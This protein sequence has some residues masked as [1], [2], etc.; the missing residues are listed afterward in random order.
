MNKKRCNTLL[1]LVQLLPAV[2]AAAAVLFALPRTAPVLAAVP[3]RLTAVVE[4]PVEAAS[5]EAEEE[6]L[7]KLPYAD[8]VYVGSSRGYGGAVRV[9]VT[10]EN[11]SIAEVEI[12]DASHETKQFLRRAK[13]LLTT[14][15]DAQSWEVDAVSEATYTSRGILGAV[16]NALTGEVVNN[17]LPPQPKPSAPLVVEEFTAPSTYRDGIY[18]AEA[19]GFEGKITVQVTVA[20]DKITDITVLSAEDEEEYLSRAKRVIPAILEGQSPNVDAV[21]GATYSSTGILNAVKLALAKAA[22]A[23]A[24][25][26]TPEQTASEEVVEEAAP[27][28]AAEPEETPVTAPT[29]EVVQPKEKRTVPAWLKEVWQQLF[30]AETPDDSEPEPASSAEVLLASEAVLPPEETEPETEGAAE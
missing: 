16:Q 20:E 21:S 12:L 2:A 5:V 26:T 28:E 10:M 7:P 4:Q 18:T 8:G 14:V 1:P 25:E 19:I 11:G 30:P 3:E 27:S 13:R 22:V 6:A 9:Q 23:P 24:E 29:V 15:M 17:P